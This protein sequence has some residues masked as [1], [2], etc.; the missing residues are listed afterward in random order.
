MHF[1]YVY[2]YTILHPLFK[3]DLCIDRVSHAHRISWFWEIHSNFQA[4]IGSRMWKKYYLYSFREFLLL[5]KGTPAHSVYLFTMHDFLRTFFY[6][7]HFVIIFSMIFFLL[8]FSYHTVL[9]THYAWLMRLPAMV[10]FP[11]KTLWWSCARFPRRCV[12]T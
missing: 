8:I 12:L 1:T 7:Y 10:K 6:V 11:R 4:H 5:T 2:S 9:V 3:W